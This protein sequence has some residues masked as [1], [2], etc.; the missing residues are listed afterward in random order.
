MLLAGAVAIGTVGY[1]LLERWS[2]LDAFYM[3][4]I[5]ISTIGFPEVHPL[6]GAGHLFTIGLVLGGVSAAAYAV[7]TIGEHMIGGQLSGTLRRRPMQQEIDQIKGHYIVCGFDRVGRQVVEN[8]QLRQASVVVVK[9][10]DAAY[11][12]SEAGPPRIR[13]DATDDRALREAGIGRAARGPPQPAWTSCPATLRAP[14][15]PRSDD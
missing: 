4:V 8:L 7:G 5:T 6:S 15:R 10:D 1:M 2:L 3:T 14:S 11:P 9:P 12:E 13:G